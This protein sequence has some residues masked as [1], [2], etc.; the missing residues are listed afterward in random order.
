M[1]KVKNNTN[2]EHLTLEQAVDKMCNLFNLMTLA[3]V[4]REDTVVHNNV[5]NVDVPLVPLINKAN[6]DLQYM[7]AKANIGD[8][9]VGDTNGGNGAMFKLMTLASV[10]DKNT[11]V[12]DTDTDS[13]LELVP[14]LEEAD[15]EF[16][17]LL[18]RI[19]QA[20]AAPVNVS[21][22]TREFIERKKAVDKTIEECERQMDNAAK[23][24][25]KWLSSSVRMLTADDV[26]EF[27]AYDG[28][29]VSDAD[30]LAVAFG[31]GIQGIIVA[32]E[33]MTGNGK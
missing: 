16:K 2:I 25:A 17:W 32:M 27:L 3:A 12:Y 22:F 26:K 28:D 8:E 21:A 33:R 4:I 7:L 10:I 1:A 29:G 18:D 30:K 24:F 5:T 15:K 23:G 31:S 11:V 20:S 14:M 9:S 13:E 19:C 6:D